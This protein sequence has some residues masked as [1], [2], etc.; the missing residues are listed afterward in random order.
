[1]LINIQG[2]LA[3]IVIIF[4]KTCTETFHVIQKGNL[5]SFQCKKSLDRSA[6][7]GE[8]DG[9]KLILIDLYVPAL[10]PRLH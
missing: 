7:M 2:I 4:I 1:M 9:L 5:P 3:A 6:L 10:T 8:S